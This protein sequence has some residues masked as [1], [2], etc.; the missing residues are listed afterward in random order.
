MQASHSRTRNRRQT[1]SP[2]DSAQRGTDSAVGQRNSSK[3]DIKLKDGRAEGVYFARKVP[4]S[5]YVDAKLRGGFSIDGL[6]TYKHM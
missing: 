1:G 6:F 5:I 3:N 4:D 2:R